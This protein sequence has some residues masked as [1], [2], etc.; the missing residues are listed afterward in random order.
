MRGHSY[1]FESKVSLRT[2]IA[3]TEKSSYE[4][5]VHLSN[6]IIDKISLIFLQGV[7]C[8]KLVLVSQVIA[9]KM[10]TV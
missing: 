2:K 5:N 7:K 8:P 9:L 6:E 3:L 4:P 1:K 10:A